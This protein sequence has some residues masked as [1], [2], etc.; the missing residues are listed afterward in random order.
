MDGVI[1]GGLVF[2]RLGARM[3]LDPLGERLT[4]N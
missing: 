3:D 4:V 2:K 1:L